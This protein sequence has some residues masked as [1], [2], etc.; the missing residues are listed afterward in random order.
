MFFPEL[1]NA[2]F[3]AAELR[4]QASDHNSLLMHLQFQLV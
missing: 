1:V 3:S 2:R 4:A